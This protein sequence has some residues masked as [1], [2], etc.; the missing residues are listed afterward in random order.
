MIDPD[1]IRWLEIRSSHGATSSVTT[2]TFGYPDVEVA[3]GVARLKIER[4][5]KNV[6]VVARVRLVDADGRV[7]R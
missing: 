6:R 7:V 4:G 3:V 5:H 2:S 1:F